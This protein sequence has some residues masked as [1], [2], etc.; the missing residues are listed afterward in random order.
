M[1]DEVSASADTG[2]QDGHAQGKGNAIVSA[3]QGKGY[4]SVATGEDDAGDI[5]MNGKSQH[6]ASGAGDEI[7][8]LDPLGMPPPSRRHRYKKCCCACVCLLLVAGVAAF[9][10]MG[11]FGVGVIHV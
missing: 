4:G 1:R 2:G 9:A 6:M 3:L 7:L 11:G 8:G 10:V 5:E